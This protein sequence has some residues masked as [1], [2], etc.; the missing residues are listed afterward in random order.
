MRITHFQNHKTD[1]TTVGALE[2]SSPKKVKTS[3]SSPKEGVSDEASVSV[4]YAKSGRSVCKGCNENIVKGALRLGASFHD[5][6]GFDQTKWYHVECFPAS[7]YPVFLVENLKGFDL[8]KVR[9]FYFAIFRILFSSLY[10][11]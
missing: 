7:S 4:E 8:I 9:A 1:Q 2:E 3:M 5:P 10:R 6:R 11:D